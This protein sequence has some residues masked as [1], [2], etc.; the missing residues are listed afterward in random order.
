MKKPRLLQRLIETARKRHEKSEEV[1]LKT[2]R[3][4][5]SRHSNRVGASMLRATPM[6]WLARIFGCWHKQ[7]SP[8][9]SQDGEIYRSCMMGGARREFNVG[10][11]KMTGA[12]YYSSPSDLYEP[13]SP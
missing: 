11:G 9:F 5:L 4:S 2:T 6:R 3:A 13:P 7:M 8:P 12:Y 1:M 10:R